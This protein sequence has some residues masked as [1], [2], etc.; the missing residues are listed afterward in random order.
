MNHHLAVWPVPYPL[1]AWPVPHPLA[2]WPVPHPLAARPVSQPLA[3]SHHLA[4]R[5]AQEDQGVISAQIRKSW[6]MLPKMYTMSIT[7]ADIF[8]SAVL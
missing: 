4:A 5:P 2:A 6:V 7:A 8:K 1:A 3:M